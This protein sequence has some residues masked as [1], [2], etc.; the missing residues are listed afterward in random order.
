VSNTCISSLPASLGSVFVLHL[1]ALT[2]ACSRKDC[3][4]CGFMV[5]TGIGFSLVPVGVCSQ[6]RGG[7]EQAGAST[8]VR[9]RWPVE[10]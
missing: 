5:G 3:A 4:F 2:V 6:H 1:A 9:R 10:L 7:E 8:Q